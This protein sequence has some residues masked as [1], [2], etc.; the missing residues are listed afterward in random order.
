MPFYVASLLPYLWVIGVF[1]ILAW[2]YSNLR[3]LH[4]KRDDWNLVATLAGRGVHQRVS[5][6]YNRNRM[7]NMGSPYDCEELAGQ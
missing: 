4:Y 2:S 6:C 3:C 5:D 1:C 7:P